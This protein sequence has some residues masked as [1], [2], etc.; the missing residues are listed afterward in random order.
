[1][2]ADELARRLYFIETTL[3]PE[4][5]PSDPEYRFVGDVAW[6]Q[7]HPEERKLKV[8]TAHFVLEELQAGPKC[9]HLRT[10]LVRLVEVRQCVDCSLLNPLHEGKMEIL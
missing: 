4:Y 2:T 8:A 10:A 7:L 6:E 9:P 1:M 5:L 3:T